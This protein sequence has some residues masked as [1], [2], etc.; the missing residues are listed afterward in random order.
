ML[1][2]VVAV[3]VTV[4]GMVFEIPNVH[5]RW[6]DSFF[7]DNMQKDNEQKDIKIM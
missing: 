2:V 7:Y 1:V 4:V 5:H 6:R 3:Y